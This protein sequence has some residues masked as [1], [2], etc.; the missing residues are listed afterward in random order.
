MVVVDDLPLVWRFFPL[1]AGEEGAALCSVTRSLQAVI[2]QCGVDSALD[3]VI[4][5]G[6][7]D[8]RS[9]VDAGT[10]EQQLQI[11][12]WWVPEPGLDN[13]AIAF[14]LALGCLNQQAEA[15]DLARSLKPPA[16]MRD[17]FPWGELAVQAALLLCMGLF[18]N[19]SGQHSHRAY[20]AVQAESTQHAWLAT[21]A[22]E[23]LEKEHN[24]LLQKVEAVRGFV[25]SRILWTSYTQDIA[26][27]L[28]DNASLE[29]FQG[30]CELPA[31]RKS[32]EA[33]SP[34]KRSLVLRLNAPI[35]PD[36]SVPQEID[37][38][39]GSLRGAP[40]AQARF[41]AGETG[42]YQVGSVVHGV[43]AH[44]LIHR[45]L[46]ARGGAYSCQAGEGKR[47]GQRRR[48]IN[49]MDTAAKIQGFKN[50]LLKRLHNPL[51]L[52]V[53]VTTLILL[54]GYLGVYVPLSHDIDATARGLETEKKRLQL[55]CEIEHLRAQ[56]DRFQHR[57]PHKADPN[58]WVQYVLGG[59]RGFPLK[60]ARLDADPPRTVGPYRAVALRIELEG[61]FR[62]HSAFLRW[63]ETN[64]R[65]FRVEAVNLM[66]HRSG[67][68]TVVMQLTV[69]GMM[70]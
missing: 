35:P 3:T 5:H 56:Y 65:L 34:P 6:R 29:S 44:G 10:L 37:G 46:P 61:A 36:G 55:A 38:F 39:L 42:G 23:R 51:Q 25:T 1:P 67:N 62:D 16:S 9:S 15:F 68:G 48:E 60:L 30:L 63:L 18:L 33:G 7:D 13:A 14:G 66:P 26:A 27:R 64:D 57:L 43:Q 21:A 69:L 50:K 17:I 59:I 32:G 47:L 52:R 54:A 8:L 2:V 4:L 20:A 41:P 58:E 45:G 31:A 28:P 11:R 70:G 22:D 53:F 12:T 24:D 40:A 49:R 19:F